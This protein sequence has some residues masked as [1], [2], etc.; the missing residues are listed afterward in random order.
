MSRLFGVILI[1]LAPLLMGFTQEDARMA[2]ILFA[3]RH[4]VSLDEWERTGGVILEF[5]DEL[6]TPS[7]FLDNRPGKKDP[8]WMLLRLEDT[9][10]RG[11]VEL[12][13]RLWTCDMITNAYDES[14]CQ[15]YEENTEYAAN[16]E[17]RQPSEDP[18]RPCFDVVDAVRDGTVRLY[19]IP[20]RNFD[21]SLL[22]SRLRVF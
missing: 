9:D 12:P 10:G 6:P 8:V 3:H 1:L 13:F 11:V 16:V 22:T 5:T 20:S 17:K 18:Q 2:R 19:R 4:F 15:S 14:G 7:L 21:R